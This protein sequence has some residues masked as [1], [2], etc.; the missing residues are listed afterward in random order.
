M[1]AFFRPAFLVA[2][3]LL[4]G[5]GVLP[6]Q[7]KPPKAFVDHR[8]KPLYVAFLQDAAALGRLVDSH[9]LKELRV[10]KIENDIVAARAQYDH[11]IDP[12]NDTAGVCADLTSEESVG[13]ENYRVTTSQRRWREVWISA[14]IA[15]N[16][17]G[18][19]QFK[20]LV[21]HELGHCLLGLQHV[22]EEP[23]QIMSPTVNGDS[24]WLDSNWQALVADMMVPGA[25]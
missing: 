14:A 15:D 18:E 24:G 13:A 23:H 9:M 22:P 25:P 20:E 8:L 4:I 10:L 11:D 6:E 1:P 2:A 21:Y 7:R 3:L 17:A 19:S 5:C 16:R 12:N